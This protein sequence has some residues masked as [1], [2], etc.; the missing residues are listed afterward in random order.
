MPS[1]QQ[2]PP[3]RRSVNLGPPPSSRR[4]MSSFY[5]TASYVSPIPEESPRNRSHTSY[6]SSAAIPESFG[7][8]SPGSTND[9]NF[10]EAIA[11]ESIYSEED[12]SRLVRSASIGKRGK[13][14]L[15]TTKGSDRAESIPIIIPASGTPP[16]ETPPTRPPLLPGVY[17]NG[18]LYFDGSSTGSSGTSSSKAQSVGAAVT[19]DRVLDAYNS[20]PAGGGPSGLPRQH[21]RLSAIRRPPRLDIEAVREAEARGSM[22]S[23]PDLIKRATRLAAMMDKGRRPASRFDDLDF[24]SPTFDRD[25]EKE[26]ACECDPDALST[27]F[28]FD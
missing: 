11:E 20:E 10:D 25:P 3:P 9:A 8:L 2:I 21:S 7:T 15:V 5:S 1:S 12:D 19:T 18:S 4:G 22:T 13:P 27:R 17:S 6:A 26:M 28:G 16:K 24:G 14:S 23:L